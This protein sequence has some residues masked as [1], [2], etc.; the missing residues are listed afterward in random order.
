MQQFR[1]T[2]F[3]VL[4]PIIKN[5]LIINVL[6]YLAQSVLGTSVGNYINNM[7]A[8]HVIQS[9]YFKPWQLFT[10]MFMHGSWMHIFSN[11]FALWM[12]G[13]ILENFWGPKRFL[14]FYIICGIGAAACQLIYTEFSLFGIEHAYANLNTHLTFDNFLQFN[15]KYHFDKYDGRVLELIHY[16]KMQPNSLDLARA[17]SMVIQQNYD[18][19]VNTETVGAS[20]AIFGV[21]VAFGYLFPNTYL[22]FYFLVPIKAKWFVTGY[23]A[24]ELYLGFQNSVGDNVA[25]MAHI[26]GGLIGFI[27]VYF[28]N[29]KNRNNFY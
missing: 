13:S 29:K 7:F 24:Y 10:Y 8:L 26:G 28:W 25:H 5:L 20:G 11:M 15:N 23:I 16:W 2:N 4:P 22:Y 27:L 14:T 12:F 19:L 1:P 6:V 3:Q 21:L 9:H 17:A 18:V